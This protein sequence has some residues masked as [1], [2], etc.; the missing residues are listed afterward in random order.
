M[1]IACAVNKVD[2]GVQ[3]TESGEGP[4]HNV[5]LLVVVGG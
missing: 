2:N 4:I 1:R 3:T 5:A